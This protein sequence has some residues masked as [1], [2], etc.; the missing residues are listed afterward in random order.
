MLF[1]WVTVGAQALNFLILVYLLKRFLYGPII[2]AMEER[3]S[4]MQEEIT[5][6]EEA[7]QEAAA[8]SQKL[9]QQQEEMELTKENMLKE[10]RAGI[11][12]W[13]E[14]AL[15]GARKHIAEQRASWL[16]SLEREQRLIAANIRRDVAA[17]V[18]ALAKKVLADLSDEEL[19]LRVVDQFLNRLGNDLPKDAITGNVLLRLGFIVAAEH[20]ER[21]VHTIH[22]Q[23]PDVNTVR[24]TVE[25]DL[26]LGITLVAGDQKWDWNLASYLEGVEDSILSSLAGER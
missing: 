6:A 19:E 7:R 4:R 11:E 26:A 5:R 3:K 24:I 21:I 16:E 10:A 13:R 8:Y 14:T 20:E 25:P 1:D 17:E 2:E 23:F 15:T 12:S 22:T 18:V 9:K